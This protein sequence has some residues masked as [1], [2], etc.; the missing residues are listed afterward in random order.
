MQ[1]HLSHLHGPKFHKGLQY[2]L[3]RS[4]GKLEHSVAFGRDLGCIAEGAPCHLGRQP[5]LEVPEPISD[6]NQS[7]GQPISG[8][9]DN[10]YVDGIRKAARFRLKAA[11]R[12]TVVSSVSKD[13]N[14]K[15]KIK[16]K[17]SH[18]ISPGLPST[19]ERLKR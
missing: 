18:A 11:V 8:Q 19:L 1:A 14:T 16:I 5:Y 3:W 15:D 10:G 12:N 2:R 17:W 9:K 6:H 13:I 4:A 7:Q